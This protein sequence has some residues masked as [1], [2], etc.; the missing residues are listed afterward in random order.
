MSGF[1]HLM[2]QGQKRTPARFTANSFSDLCNAIL[3]HRVQIS[4]TSEMTDE[5]RRKKSRNCTGSLHQRRKPGSVVLWRIWR[6]VPSALWTLTRALRRNKSSHTS[7]NTSF[8]DGLHD[9]SHTAEAPRLRIVCELS[10]PIEPAER[11]AILTARRNDADA[12]RRFYVREPGGP[13]ITLGERQR[14]RG[15]RSQCVRPAKLPLLPS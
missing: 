8:C 4:I 10:R 2:E 13:K 1:D 15:I 9:A 3:S 5:E 12:E 11:G 7:F 14:L 6:H